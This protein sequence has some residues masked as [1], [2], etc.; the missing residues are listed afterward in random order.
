MGKIILSILALVIVAS[1]TDMKTKVEIEANTEKYMMSWKKHN[2]DVV[3]SYMLN[4][5]KIEAAK[6]SVSQRAVIKAVKAQ[7]ISKVNYKTFE[8]TAYTNGY[9]STQRHKGEKGYGITASGEET[10]V[11]YTVACPK[12]MKLGTKLYIPDMKHTY[13]CTD[14]GGAIKSGKLDIYMKTVKEAIS[15]GRRKLAVQV[16]YPIES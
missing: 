12:T 3:S 9:E 4:K 2:S 5:K 6:K 8:I 14:R 7:V 13:V 10:K 16:I 11:N 1:C 15:F